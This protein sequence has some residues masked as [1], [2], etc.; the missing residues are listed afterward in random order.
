MTRLYL[1]V[2]VAVAARSAVAR[3]QTIP[4][5]AF[6][7]AGGS[8]PHSDR[9]GETYFRDAHSNIL[10]LGA[11]VRLLTIADRV[12]PVVRVDY[13]VPNMAV[14]TSICLIAPNDSCR[15]P[16][17]QTDGFS[18]GL[19]AVVMPTAPLLIGATA[20]FAR[21]ANSRRYFAVNASYQ[22]LKHLAALVDWRYIDV[23]YGP[24]GRVWFRPVQA[25]VRVY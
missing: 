2:L 19:G 9:Q 4:R 21:S 20:G 15:R 6:E 5:V 11:A 1:A 25:G 10:R 22:V 3:A 13:H 8:G 14:T 18:V 7:L 12:A 17:P 24:S 16:F 23:R